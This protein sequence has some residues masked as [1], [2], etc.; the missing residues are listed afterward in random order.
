MLHPAGLRTSANN[1]MNNLNIKENHAQECA[2]G[3]AFS[4]DVKNKMLRH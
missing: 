4:I 2:K 3:G 1:N